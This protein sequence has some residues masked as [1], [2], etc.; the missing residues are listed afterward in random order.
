MILHQWHK[1]Q[2]REYVKE[3]HQ[4]LHFLPFELSSL[5]LSYTE[6]PEEKCGREVGLL[7]CCVLSIIKKKF[8]SIL[9]GKNRNGIHIQKI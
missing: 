7:V 2:N 8:W 4:A 1:Y 3:I 9:M 6:Y 5:L